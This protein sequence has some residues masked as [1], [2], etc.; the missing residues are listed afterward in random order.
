MPKTDLYSLGGLEIT[1]R[2]SITV[3][4]AMPML[5][6]SSHLVDMLETRRTI[7]Q[8]L[9]QLMSDVVHIPWLL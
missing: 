1:P 9:L 6:S 7:G 5:R 3:S 2:I 8:L 4:A